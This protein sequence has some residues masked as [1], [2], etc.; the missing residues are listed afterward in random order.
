MDV[1]VSKLKGRS[2]AD[3][4]ELRRAFYVGLELHWCGLADGVMRGA[5]QI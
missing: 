2:N 1:I 5:R 3:V 4:R